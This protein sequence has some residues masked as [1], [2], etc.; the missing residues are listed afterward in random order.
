MVYTSHGHTVVWAADGNVEYLGSKH[1]PLFAVA[2][3][4]LVLLWFSYTLLHFL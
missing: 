4:I 2:V 3:A 1:A